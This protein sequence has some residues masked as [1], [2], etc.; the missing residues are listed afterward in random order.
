MRKPP[1]TLL[2]AQEV[3]KMRRAGKFAAELLHHLGGLLRPG[4]ST[5]ALDDEADRFVRARGGRNGPLGFNGYPKS[6]CT[7]INNVVCHG[8][9]NPQHILKEG[10]IIGIDVSPKLDG[11]HG[12][13]CKTFCIGE[14]SQQAKQLI[15]VTR[16]CM[17]RGIAQVAPG[18]RIGDIGAAISEHAATFSYGVVRDFCGHGVGRELHTQPDILHVAKWGTGMRMQPGMAFTIEPMINMG[19]WRIDILSDGWTAVTRDGRLSAQFEHTLLVTDTGVEVLTLA[20][21]ES[22]ADYASE[23]TS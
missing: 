14:G 3:A 8:I 11:Y 16:A 13:T 23:S 1:I 15:E 5:Q 9:P 10:D 22:A 7:S 20:P 2:S 18:K 6:I 4:L 19:N 12:D 21:G 17:W